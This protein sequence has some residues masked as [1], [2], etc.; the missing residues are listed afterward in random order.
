M[1]REIVD[2]L[3]GRERRHILLAA[4]RCCGKTSLLNAIKK[5]VQDSKKIVVMMDCRKED[6]ENPT[7]FLEKIFNEARRIIAERHPGSVDNIDFFWQD[8][9]ESFEGLFDTIKDKFDLIIL[10]V[11]DYDLLT[12][13]AQLIRQIGKI[14]EID[15]YCL[16]L[17]GEKR[18]DS[19]GISGLYQTELDGFK[20]GELIEYFNSHNT[21]LTVGERALIDLEQIV[22]AIGIITAGRPGAVEIFAECI[23]RSI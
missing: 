18:I 19:L 22:L 21:P 6:P 5:D 14:S 7:L 3:S 15:G 20:K 13:N 11:D 8:P 23:C 4:P 10:L 2:N 1:R 17:A 9:I 12:S 16:I